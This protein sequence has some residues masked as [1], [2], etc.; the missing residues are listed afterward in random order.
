MRIALEHV[1]KEY[2]DAGSGLVVLNDVTYTFEPATSYSIV[3]QSGIG[4]S[5]LLHILGGLDDPS[6]G[7]ISFGDPQ[8]AIQLAQLDSE[9]RALF[10]REH[11]GFVFQFHHL[12][13]DFS[14]LENVAMPLLI[15]GFSNK[16]AFDRAKE[17]LTLFGLEQRISQRPT[18]LSG[19]EQQRVAIARALVHR[20]KVLLADEPTGNLDVKT[21]HEVE[22]VL[23]EA[24]AEYD[25]TMIL[26][27]H[28]PKLAQSASVQ[29]SMHAGGDLRA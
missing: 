16:D 5:T 18:E 25:F 17:Y 3:G 10:R 7:S 11:L 22:Q 21:A 9:Q 2:T 20:P 4:K 8:S 14:A 13:P 15:S 12:L 6:K 1:T 27:T 23:L 28:N 29:L 26:V 19:G 24:Q